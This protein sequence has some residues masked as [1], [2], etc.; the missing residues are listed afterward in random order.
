[1]F[2]NLAWLKYRLNC[3]LISYCLCIGAIVFAASQV[4]SEISD[5]RHSAGNFKYS[6]DTLAT[7]KIAIIIDDVGYNWKKGEQIARLPGP[8]TISI[9][10]RSPFGTRLAKLSHELGKE[11]M[12]HAP[13]SNIL[14]KPLD[15]GALTTDMSQ[16]VFLK[17]LRENLKALPHAVGVNNHMGS[18]L[19]QHEEPMSW[20][21]VELKRQHLYFIDSRTS[22]DSQ[23]WEIAQKHDLPS[24]KRDFFLDHERG[25]A[26]IAEQFEQFI[27]KAKRDGQGIAIAHPYPE[28][29]ALLEEKIPLLALQDIELI[30]ISQLLGIDEGSFDNAISE[31]DKA[32][33]DG[34]IDYIDRFKTTILHK[35]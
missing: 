4:H 16:Q 3:R 29:L 25:E 13:M 10:P 27:N 30:S 17:I 11:V 26:A 6:K 1:M 31:A 21:M 5:T 19:T 28:T 23:A 34:P 7:T 9:L 32:V 18:L 22:P 20:L 33:L 2:A 24:S 35:K 12:L 15:D 14:D 8:V